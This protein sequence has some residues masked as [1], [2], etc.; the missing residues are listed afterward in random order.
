MRKILLNKYGNRAIS[1]LH[2]NSVISQK[3]KE[4]F[5]RGYKQR[6]EQL[7]QKRTLVVNKHEKNS[8]VNYRHKWLRFKYVCDQQENNFLSHK[9]TYKNL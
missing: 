5:Q 9:A 4:K 7:I 3:V 2:K 1:L 6:S 8:L